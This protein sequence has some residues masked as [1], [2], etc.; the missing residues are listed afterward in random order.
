MYSFTLSYNRIQLPPHGQLAEMAICRN[1]LFINNLSSC[2]TDP[3]FLG[4]TTPDCCRE[5]VFN[6]LAVVII[7]I[8]KKR[9]KW[10]QKATT[11]MGN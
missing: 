6:L 3:V 9:K 1:R 4:L 8:F 5:L 11:N 10:Q 2:I 7:D